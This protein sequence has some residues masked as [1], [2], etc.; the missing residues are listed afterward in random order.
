[1]TGAL[2]QTIASDG[3]FLYVHGSK[4]LFKI[5]TGLGGTTPGTIYGQVIGFRATEKDAT[6][7][8]VGDKLY[9][10]SSQL[11]PSSLLVLDCRYLLEIG[12]VRADGSGSFP[13]SNLSKSCPVLASDYLSGSAVSLI[14]EGLEKG[15]QNSRTAASGPSTAPFPSDAKSESKKSQDISRSQRCLTGT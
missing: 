4:G 15:K 12:R 14:S 3:K 10:R 11:F 1:M 9:Y 8:C 2:F 7:A 13:S 5:G 6:L